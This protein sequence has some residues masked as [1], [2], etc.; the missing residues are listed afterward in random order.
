MAGAERWTVVEDVGRLRDGLGVPVPPGTPDVFADPVEDPLAD[1]VARYARTHGPFT[2]DQVSAGSPSAR[3]W[4]GTPCSA[5]PPR[6]GCW[7]ASS[8]P[9]GSGSEWCDAEVLRTLRRRSLARLR[10]EVEPVAAGRPGPVPRRLAARRLAH[11]ACAASTACSP[12]STSS[13]APRAGLCAR[14]AG[15]RPPG[16]ATTSRPTSTSSPPPARWSGPATARC[17]AP[18][19]GCRCTSPTRPRSRCPSTPPFERQRAAR[20]GAGRPRARRRVVLPP[21]RRLRSGRPTTGRCQRRPVGLVW[22]G[23]ISNDTL[24]PL[25]ALTRGGRRRT[26]PR[27]AAAARGC[28][29]PPGDAAD[30]RAH[31]SAR[32]GRPLGA[33]A[34]RSTPT[35]PGAPTPRPSGCS[36]GTAW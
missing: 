8:A 13:P 4:S 7:T 15:A 21:A 29:R 9:S 14:V 2:T 11:E 36:T 33:A 23:R 25:R 17:P 35:P 3:P 27:A 22:A 30:A 28:P 18:T 34:R 31:R 5:W 6:A 16:C 10:K 20:E 19:A 32:D 12:S 24:T 1:L 26:A